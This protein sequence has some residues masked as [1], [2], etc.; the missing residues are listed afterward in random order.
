[1]NNKLI[2]VAAAIACLATAHAQ[3]TI[4]G[5]EWDDPLKTSVNR[6]TAHT[7]AI[8]MASDADIAQNDMTLSPYYQSLN[9]TWKFQWV[10][11]PTSAKA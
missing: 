9:G 1:M 6:E 10:G 7:L 5:K 3:T 11:L 2:L 4:T 8:P